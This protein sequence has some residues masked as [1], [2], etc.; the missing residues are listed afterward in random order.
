MGV[1]FKLYIWIRSVSGVVGHRTAFC[2]P[3]L[4]AALVEFALDVF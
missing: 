2:I 4:D 3:N 1:E